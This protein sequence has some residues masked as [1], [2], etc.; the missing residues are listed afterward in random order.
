MRSRARDAFLVA[1]LLSATAG[2]SWLVGV[3]ED[4]VVTDGFGFDA[5]D[6]TDAQI[7]ADGAGDADGTT[8]TPVDDAAPE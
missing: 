8:H 1:A 4:P 2:C 3:S 6:E 5:G 7:A